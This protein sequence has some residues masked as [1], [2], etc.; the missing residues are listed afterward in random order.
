MTSF[1]RGVKLSPNGPCLG[2]RPLMPDGTRGPY[3][4][5]TYSQVQK[6]CENFGSGLVSACGLAA[7]R[8]FFVVVSEI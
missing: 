6:R 2:T 3:E 8:F 1:R 5:Q 4:W 7:V